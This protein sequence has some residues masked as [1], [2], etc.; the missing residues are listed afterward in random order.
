[1]TSKA[2]PSQDDSTGAPAGD[3]VLRAITDDDTFRVM[4][5]STTGVTRQSVALQHATGS[6]ARFFADL[7]TGTVLIRE[8]MA[9]AYRLQSVLKGTDQQGSLVA[10]AHP[11]GLT[12]GLVQAPP[13]GRPFDTSGG[14]MLQVMRSMATGKVHRSVVRPPAADLPSKAGRKLRLSSAPPAGSSS[15]TISAH[16][17]NRSVRHTIG[18]L[19]VPASTCPGQRTTNGTR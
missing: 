18:S 12:R 17:A 19:E 13:D 7:L 4:V 1:M 9:P 3:H 15:P 14:A 5:A 6:T 2:K 10:D 11:D 16:V 8:T